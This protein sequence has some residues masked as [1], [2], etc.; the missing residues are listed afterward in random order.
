MIEMWKVAEAKGMPRSAG[1]I[2][3]AMRLAVAF[4]R[5]AR[6]AT[7]IEYALIAILVSVAVIAGATQMGTKLPGYFN[8][9]GNNLK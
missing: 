3:R 7:A 4:S 9:V 8:N 5:D 2:D 6:G 1:L